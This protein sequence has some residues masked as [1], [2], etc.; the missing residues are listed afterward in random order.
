MGVI[1]PFRKLQLQEELELPEV[2]RSLSKEPLTDQN[3]KLLAARYYNNP[4][5]CGSEEFEQDLRRIKYIKKA[6]T[7]YRASGELCDRL[8]LNHL[9]VMVNV[10]GPPF[11]TR[12][13]F[14]KMRG[15]LPYIKP[16]LVLLSALP[17]VVVDVDGR[18]WNTD[19][20]EMDMDVV[21]VLRSIR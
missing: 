1:I 21:E 3:W 7:R 5:S 10:F 4:Q 12:L 15:Y 14:L 17:D 11:T 9:I 16:F 6:I 18:D 19:E 2:T 8:I 13:I 20:I